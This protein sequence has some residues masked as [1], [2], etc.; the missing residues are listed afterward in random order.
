MYPLIVLGDEFADRE[1][2]IHWKSY[3][4]RSMYVHKHLP[5]SANR[6]VPTKNKMIR[7]R[8]DP[9]SRC[10]P[11]SAVSYNET[12]PR[13]TYDWII[14][15][16]HW[17]QESIENSEIVSERRREKQVVWTAKREINLK[18]TMTKQKSKATFVCD[19]ARNKM[20]HI[21]DM[22]AM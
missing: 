10:R 21:N 2:E 17:P 8:R 9:F 11:M 14:R 13:L 4:A 5:P 6:C 19:L 12:A 16:I 18:K 22:H 20:P 15:G 3:K 7:M 1:Y